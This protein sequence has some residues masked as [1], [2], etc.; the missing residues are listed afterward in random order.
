[1]LS[2]ELKSSN[3]KNYS[4][5]ELNSIYAL[6]RFFL[7]TGQLRN[8]E[9]IFRGLLS[10]SPIFIRAYLGLIYV[11]VLQNQESECDV[12]I[13]HAKNLLLSSNSI[14]ENKVEQQML[15]Q[16]L[17]FESIVKLTLGDLVQAGT[18][19]GEVNDL[20]E[21]GVIDDPSILKLFKSQ[22]ARYHSI[23]STGLIR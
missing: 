6:G 7:Q 15:G 2:A 9:Q 16:V 8:S 21:R 18:S 5:D 14:T 4:D 20:V 10:V 3:S 11:L 17:L 1:M 19:L 23:K 13:D 22:L 12:L